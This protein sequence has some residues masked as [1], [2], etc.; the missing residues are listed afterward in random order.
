MRRQ[1]ATARE[2]HAVIFALHASRVYC[3]SSPFE[4]TV[5]TDCRSLIFV[6]DSTKSELSSRFLDKLQDIRYTIRYRRGSENIV[7]DAFSRL[8][9]HGPD[10]LSPAGTATALD[11][12][13]DHL[14]GTAAQKAKNVWV[15]VSEYTDDAYRLTQSWRGR[16]G[17]GGLMSKSAP[18][19]AML[20]TVHDLR[21]LR[22][23]PHVA[24]ELS[25][26][27]L[28][29]PIPTAILLPLDLTGQIGADSNGARIPGILE[30][31][32]AAKK[33]AYVGGNALWLLHCIAGAEDDVCLAA[34]L[35]DVPA[36]T[37]PLAPLDSGDGAVVMDSPLQPLPDGT[38]LEHQHYGE[39]RHLLER[40]AL[41]LDIA[42][43]AGEQTTDGLS[44]SELARVVTDQRDLKWLQH[45]D[46]PDKLLVPVRYRPL[47][48]QLVHAESNHAAADGLQREI[49]SGSM[50]DPAENMR[51]TT[52]LGC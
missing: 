1:G 12:L 15:Y 6:K 30:A 27:V 7:A 52:E 36:T 26:E 29:Q 49:T 16:A 4:V 10:Q 18:T 35:A 43:W 41:D 5:Y 38:F 40:L 42:T 20:N 22:F 46:E 2:A 8:D 24:V 13:F 47:I 45:E 44:T 14:T 21:I 17:V 33:R 23:D 3:H 31:V 32:R 51:I 19:E 11:D 34:T 9:L 28:K 48:L 39:T 50:F 37:D 25:R